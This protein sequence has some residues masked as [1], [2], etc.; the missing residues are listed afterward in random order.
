M[1]VSIKTFRC[2]PDASDEAL[3][4]ALIA[5]RQYRDHYAGEDPEEQAQDDLHGPYWLAAITPSSFAPIDIGAATRE[6]QAWADDFEGQ[7]EESQRRLASQVFPLLAGD[8]IY[9]LAD[10]RQTAEHEWGWVVGNAGFY[11][12]VVIDRPN[13]RLS[14]LVASDD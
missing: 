10:L 5:H 1:W 13:P 9:R 14:L 2:A 11:E 4:T 8:Q 3:L 7:G 6:I 12:Y